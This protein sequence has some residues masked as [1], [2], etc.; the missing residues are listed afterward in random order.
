[1]K[2]W[3]LIMVVAAALIAVTSAGAM[4]ASRAGKIRVVG[5]VVRA[6]SSAGDVPFTFSVD[7]TTPAAPDGSYGTF[8]GSFP[9]DPAFPSP[10]DFAS[11]SGNVTCLHVHGDIA[12]V[13]GV[14]TSGYGFDDT[15]TSPQHDLTGDWFITQVQD[16]P[17]GP[18]G[19]AMGYVDWGDRYYFG[20]PSNFG[21]QEFDS[22]QALCDN[23][24]ADLGTSEFPLVSGDIRIN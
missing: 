2:R 24:A 23:P 17:G 1:M 8:S 18:S 22:F 13:G 20:D 10:G 6:A 16:G 4:P 3:S 5:S 7:A 9:N 15:Y 21:G 19:D 14:I 12:T 11:F